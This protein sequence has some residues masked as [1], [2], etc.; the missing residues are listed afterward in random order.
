MAAT[1][2]VASTRSRIQDSR[3]HELFIEEI[4]WSQQSA[5]ETGTISADDLSCTRTHLAH[6]GGVAVLEISASDGVIPPFKG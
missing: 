6:L 1:L 4:G 2:N 3:F 5:R